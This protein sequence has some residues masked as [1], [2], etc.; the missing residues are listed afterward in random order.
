MTYLLLR[1]N[2]IMRKY[3]VAQVCEHEL[4]RIRK[5]DKPDEKARIEQQRAMAV[6]AAVEALSKLHTQEVRS[7][8]H[9]F[10]RLGGTMIDVRSNTMEKS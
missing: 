10:V 9:H 4:D 6:A 8:L 1:W 2:E 7:K 5:L 3:K